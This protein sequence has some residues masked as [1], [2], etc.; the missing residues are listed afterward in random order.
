MMLI[1]SLLCGLKGKG[2]VDRETFEEYW[3]ESAVN[4][5]PFKAYGCLTRKLRERVSRF[6]DD[7][8]NANLTP[9]SLHA[10]LIQV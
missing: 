3:S 6:K 5:Y 4:F 2:A 1:C 10:K 8:F 9:R 7:Y